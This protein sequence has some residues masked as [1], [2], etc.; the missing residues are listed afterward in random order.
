DLRTGILREHRREDFIT[1]LA[2]V[3]YDPGATCPLWQAFLSRIMDRNQGLVGYLQRAVGYALT[4]NV[5]EQCL[6]FLYGAGANGKTTFLGTVENMLGD[7]GIHAVSDLLTVRACEQHPTER[8]DLH[9]RR[10]VACIEQEDGK[11]MAESLM[12]QLTGGDRIRAR[13]MRED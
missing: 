5:E 2:P 8:A 3:A 1:K 12:K 4:G 7:Y 10:F 9:G 6:F 11:R 13:R